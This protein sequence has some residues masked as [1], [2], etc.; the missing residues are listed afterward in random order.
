MAPS[1]RF[2]FLILM[3]FPYFSSSSPP[4]S[5]DDT[6]TPLAGVGGGGGGGTGTGTGGTSFFKFVN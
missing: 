3:N 1:G 4:V 5:P 2:S 6:V